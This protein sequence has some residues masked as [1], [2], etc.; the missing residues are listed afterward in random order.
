MFGIAQRR[1]MGFVNNELDYGVMAWD[2]VPYSQIRG[3]TAVNL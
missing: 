2:E 3:G 1:M